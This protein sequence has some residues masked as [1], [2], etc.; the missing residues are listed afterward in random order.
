M[1]IHNF[2]LQPLTKQPWPKATLREQPPTFNQTTL[3]KGHA[4][5]TTSNLQP[6]N[7]GQRPRY[8][9][10]LQPSTFKHRFLTGNS[11]R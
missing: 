8:A 5:R 10:N 2:N 4:T 3:A 9:N 7:L 6:N 1:I 11:A